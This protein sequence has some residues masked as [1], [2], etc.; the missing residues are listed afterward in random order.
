MREP[1]RVVRMQEE[2]S[3]KIEAIP[4]VSSVGMG[5]SIPMDGN[6]SLNPVFAQDRTYAEGQLPPLRHFKFVSPGYIKT[7]GTPLVA[8]RDFTWTDIYDKRP[9]ALVSENM[10]REYWGGPA[11]ALGKRIR[12]STA[13]DWC[14]IVGVL[15]DVHENGVNVEAPSSVDWPI[16]MRHLVRRTLAVA[17]RS[18][19]AGTEGLMREVRQAVW[20]VDP[21]LPLA[22]V[23]TLEYFYR[24]SMART[25]FTLVMLGVAAIMALL[26]GVVGLYGVIAYSVSQ[27]ARE[28]GIRMALGA[29][30]QE[31]TGMF[32]R[33]GLLLTSVGVA[34]GLAAAFPLMRLMS[35]LLFEVSAVDPLTY[36]VVSLGLVATAVLASYL[37][38][39]RAAA[40][41]PVEALRAE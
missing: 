26:L 14:E 9:V 32:V 29:Q 21:N 19:R 10:G 5:T 2:I 18:P 30:Q 6:V 12:V 8:G 27:R 20:S 35:S 11:E 1:E 34:C 33:Q 16:M 40:V 24:K 4:G 31:L 41:D 7:L 15:A 3:R 22:D 17:I 37:P 23:H 36:G 25:S 39:R 28:I 38:S 13:D